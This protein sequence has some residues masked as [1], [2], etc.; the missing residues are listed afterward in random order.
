M[1][2]HKIDLGGREIYN[3][4]RLFSAHYY[5]ILN[6]SHLC[7]VFKRYISKEINKV[8]TFYPEICPHGMKGH[9]IYHFLSPYPTDA[10]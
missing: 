2:Y 8:C 9:Q 7:P 4:G 5:Y 6:S 1:P 3:S 10:R